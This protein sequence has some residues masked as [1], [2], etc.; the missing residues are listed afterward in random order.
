L[1][2]NTFGQLLDFFDG[3][4]HLREGVISVLHKG[5]FIDDPTRIF[6]AVRFEQ[7]FG[8]KIDKP[9]ERLIK[10]AIKKDMFKKTG[11]TRILNELI[12]I[13][14]E[15]DPARAIKRMYELDELKFI[16]S[17]IKMEKKS[18]QFFRAIDQTHHWYKRSSLKKETLDAW[19]MYLM[20]LF[21]NLDSRGVREIC[22][23]FAFSR[24]DKIRIISYKDEGDKVLKFLSHKKEVARSQVFEKLNVLSYEVILLIMA[25]AKQKKAKKSI[26]D[27][28][29]SYNN[30]RIKTT[31]D[32]LDKLGF[33]PGPNLGK[34]LK[35]I[36]YAK[37]DGKIRTKKEELAFAERLLR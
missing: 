22:R 27:F 3:Q 10:T 20:A 9:T 4:K 35:K 28:L 1:N 21:E 25:K 23:R 32:D 11:N 24:R 13:L 34:A 5:S 8:F 29:L 30:V 37:I 6:R 31:G 33:E 2:R 26:R 18:A 16:H 15:K 7:R 17:K 12:L 36:L 14:K 19:L